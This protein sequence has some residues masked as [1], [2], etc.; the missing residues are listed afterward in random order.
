M[1]ERQT[2]ANIALWLKHKSSYDLCCNKA[3]ERRQKW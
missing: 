3:K 2:V 1:S